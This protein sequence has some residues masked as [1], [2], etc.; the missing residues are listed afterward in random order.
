MKLFDLSNRSKPVLKWAGGKSSLLP[1]LIHLFPLKFNRYI[2]PFLGGGAVFFAL[3][4]GFI[5][6]LVND[7]NT[8]IF[9]LYR[10]IRDHPNELIRYLDILASKYSE[11]FYYNIRSCYPE[12]DIEKAARTL[13]LN[14]TGYNGLFRLNSKGQFNVPFGKRTKCPSLYDKINI[15]SVSNRFQKAKL[16]NK[17]FE[18]IINETGDGDFIYCDPPYEPISQT[19]SFNTYNS[20]GFS[21]LEQKRL[22]DVCKSAA[23]RGAIVAISNSIAPSIVELYKNSAI[24]RVFAKRSINSI[25]SGRGQVEEI[26]AVLCK[27]SKI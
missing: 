9:I 10:I 16:E 22:F 14:K 25:G 17:D 2:E 23:N 15:L 21:F 24:Y 5:P 27:S 26:L 11:E 19:S 1:Q 8:E 12:N 4:S 3:K 6:S 18:E 20:G 13:F 7:Y